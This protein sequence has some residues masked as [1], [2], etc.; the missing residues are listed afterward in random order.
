MSLPRVPSPRRTAGSSGTILI[1]DAQLRKL[2]QH[3]AW[4]SRKHDGPQKTRPP[5]RMVSLTEKGRSTFRAWVE[6]PV[7]LPRVFRLHF[8][9]KLY[10]AR[11]FGSV[12]IQLLLSRQIETCQTLLNTLKEEL[13]GAA[14]APPAPSGI[15]LHD[16]R[17]LVDQTRMRQT[18]A[19]LSWLRELQAREHSL[20]HSP[21]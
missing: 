4:V 21:S 15:A 5:R 18:E 10:L 8:L 1:L 3:P 20:A 16:F 12:T 13:S 7:Q 9:L 19:T 11:S 2:A 17:I 14:G 6:I